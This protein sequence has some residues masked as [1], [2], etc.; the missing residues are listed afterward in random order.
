MIRRKEKDALE[1]ETRRKIY[2]C[3]TKFPGLHERELSKKLEMPLSTLVYHLHYLEKRDLIMAKEDGRYTRYYPTKKI[4]ARAK[5][6]MSLLRQKMPRRIIMFLLL[7][8]NAYHREICEEVDLA[9]STTS[10]HLKKLVETNIAKKVTIGKETMYVINEPETVS[11]LLI[12]Y[13]ES[14]LDSAVDRFADTWLKF[15]PQYIRKKTEKKDEEKGDFSN[16]FF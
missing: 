8:P 16:T 4:G 6:I 2:R 15:G 3:I 14:F 7:H 13:K 11:D 1:L 12:T 5:E 10:F 9:P